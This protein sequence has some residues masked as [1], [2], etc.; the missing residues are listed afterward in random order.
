MQG[1]GFGSG[2]SKWDL[3]DWRW[4]GDLF[5]AKQLNSVPTD[6]RNRQLFPVDP[7][8][9]DGSNNLVSGEGSRELEKR[10]RGFFD[11]GLE[12]ND[13]FGSLNLNLG[14]QVYPIM[15]GEERSGKKTKIT[16]TTTSNRAVCQVEDCRA[17][18][19]NAKDYHRRHKVC[20]VHSKASKA[21]VGNVMQRFCQ[22]CSRFHV[23]EEFD[24]GKRSCRRRLLGHNIR[25][26]KVHLDAAGSPI[27]E[28]GTSYLLPSILRIL[29]NMQSNEADHLGN[30]DVLSRLLGNLASVTGA[31]NGRNI[32]SFLEGF[33]N[34][35]KAGTSGAAQN[36]PNTNP[37]GSEAPRPSDSSLKMNNNLIHQDPPESR[38]QCATVPSN[39][40]APKCIPSSSVG[41]PP[42]PVAVETTAGRNGLINIDLNNVY[43][44]AQDVENPESSRP[45]VASGV[46]SHDHPS[47]V[48]Y[49]S[50]KSSPPQTSRN[51]DST[52][53][54]SPSSS[55]G[56]GQSRTDRI[57]FKLFGKDPNDFP[58][59]LRSQILSWLSHS[60]TEIESYIRPGCIILTIC[61]RLENSAWDELCYNLGSSL[62]KLLA[63]SNDSI[64]RI[65]LIYTRVR[66]S[67][68]I[69]YNGQVFL[70]MPL[71]LG[72]QENCQILCVKPLAVS[73]STDV[74]FSVKGLNLFLNSAR[75]LC[76]LEGKYLVEDRCYDLIDGSGAATGHHELQNLSFSCRIPNMSGRGFIE[77]EDDCLGSCSFPF[78]VAEPE[79]CSEICN[80]ETVI[81]AAET[82]DDI[83]IKAKLME[84][85]TRAMNFVQEMG[86][87]LH[88]IRVKYRL[89][90]AA[91][92]QDRFHFNRYT[93]LVGFSM[94]HDWCAVMK[95]L[96][97]I[98]FEG[99]VDTGEHTSA[100]LALLNM[101]LLHKAV[102]RNCRPMV[103]LLLNFVPIKASDGG[104]SKEMQVN[105]SPDRFLFRPDAVG[106]AGLTPLHVAASMNGY[107]TVLDALTDDPGMVGIEAWKSAKDNTGLTPNDYASLKGHYS[108]I[109]LVQ[110]KTTKN[111]P[112]QHVV[113]IP[114]TLV[115]G[116]T[117]KQ[118]DGH[119]SSKVSSFNT[120][121]IA[122]MP[123]HCGLCQ[124]KLAYSSG[125]GGTRRA[126]VYR[127]AMLSMVAIA[128]VCVCVAL[129]FK[130]SP[131]VYYVFQPFSWESLEYGSM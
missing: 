111:N 47:F 87:L 104:D 25:R 39:H 11:E 93:W 122:T 42:R 127:P 43:D 101:G 36:V 82:A 40:T 37:I 26:R 78:I 10:R 23:L 73:A 48:Q 126:L 52:S 31:V 121:N 12:V 58:D 86:W 83:Q 103:E 107:E 14:G 5:T 80:L 44:D 29:S 102:K 1:G 8:N 62:R 85:K 9:V 108:Y 21:L 109:Q 67:V 7:E 55:S 28:R 19:S 41:L 77:V 69:L 45:Y 16:V 97:D 106:P 17:D 32:A 110:R 50:L 22:Q 76:A 123:N 113:D 81:E 4:D 3:N 99:E 88:R 24:E 119:K 94:D 115:D 120:E 114:G 20:V 30:S 46:G 49:E 124:Q 90:P 51:S 18:L 100:E 129:L 89:G 63:A 38:L 54:Q 75:I 131:R 57:V 61:L 66:N 130:S 117:K 112:T 72:S 118:L 74:K 70:D 65:G 34:L 68:A 56:E 95:K 2:S 91:P 71:R 33:Q 128:A 125:I 105:K 13:D 116:N 15:E 6:C 27:E 92:V 96:L 35:V 79:I 84:E 53:T 98:I 60:P 59:V 64:W